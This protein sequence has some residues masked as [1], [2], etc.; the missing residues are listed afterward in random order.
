[1][2]LETA[3][4]PTSYEYY[5]EGGIQSGLSADKPYF[6]LNN[7]NISIYSGA[8]HYFRVPKAYWRDRLRKVRAA[9]LNTVETY[10]PWNLHEPESGRFDFGNGGSDFQEFLD[11]VEFLR[12]AQQE[13]LFAI[14]RPGP[15]ICTEWDFGGLPSWLLRD[16]GIK[17]RTSEPTYMKY[18][19]RY[20]SMLLPMLAALQFINGGPIIAFQVENEYG[21]TEQKGKFTPDKEY[22]RELRSIM[23]S[24]GIKELLV[25]S[26]SPSLHGTSGTLPEYFLQTANFG[27]FPKTDFDA[28]KKLQPGKPIMAMEFWAGWFDHWSEEHHVRKD[29][30]F[31][32]VFKS[33]LEYPGSVN[34]Y[35]FHGGTNFG[36]MNGANLNNG[37]T[38]NSGFQPDTTSYDYDA[39]L[40]EA[41]DYTMKYVFIKELL[42]QFNPVKTKIPQTPAISNKVEYGS[43]PVQG[44]M[45]LDQI[46]ENV[47]NVLQST[48]VMPMELLPINYNSGQSYGYIIYR[49]RNLDISGDSILKIAGRVCDSV[50]VLVN[51]VLVSKPLTSSK[52]LNEFGFWRLKDSN[53]T[54]TNQDLTNATLDLVVENWGRVNFGY[55][56]QFNQ[57][58]GLWQGSVYI[59]N[60]ELKEWDIIPLEFK[61]SWN[62]ALKNWPKPGNRWAPGPS[63]YKSTLTVTNPQDTYIDMRNWTKGIVII[64]GFVLGR[65]SKIGPQQTLYLP[66]PFL[67]IG[68]NN[69]I[70]FEHYIPSNNLVFSK[71]PI[72]LTV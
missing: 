13:D 17:L 46:I 60:E 63:L 3:A 8:V 6:T 16:R 57:Y 7:R 33:I 2:A 36:F 44:Q 55:L 52:D 67:K 56:E 12:I 38:D 26:D 53:I 70:I 22:L 31:Y 14:V 15:F 54:L 51:G 50:I 61:T 35:M 27:G 39:P 41:G 30:E 18:V 29:D 4:L 11:V 65:Y 19:R 1:M 47:P 59:N 43:I 24:N 5:T 68:D 72:F 20:F 45:L 34:I 58:K 42:N 62:N 28:L 40:S 49:K 10:I 21:S 71:N 48:N 9:G 37:R 66:A 32:Q 25:T 69:I 23:L 64:N